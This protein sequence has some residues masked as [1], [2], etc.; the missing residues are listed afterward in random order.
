MS[1]SGQ[2]N[3]KGIFA[4]NWAALS[5]FLQFL[6][7]KNFA[8]IQLEPN[9]SEDFN[10][11]F[12]D[13]KKII[14][15]SKYKLGQF[16]YSQLKEVLEKIVERGSVEGRDEI[17]IVCRSVGQELISSTKNIRFS[18]FNKN[19][20]VK[21]K[22]K[23]FSEELFDL[24]PRVNFWPLGQIEDSDI[25]YSL[26]ADL[27]NLWVPA[28]EIQRFTNDILQ[29]NIFKKA[30][31]GSVYSREDFNKDLNDFRKEV[32]DR[33]DFFNLKKS[34]EEQ[35]T[36]LEGDVKESKGIEWGTGSV[37]AFSARWDLMSFA[38]DRL[39][40]RTDLNL[41]KWDD[42]W[43]LNRVYYFAFGI[44]SVFENNIVNDE[45]RRY[46]V[47][48]V[49]KYIKNIRG[50]YRS[51]FFDIHIVT[52]LTIIIDN[53]G[54]EKYLTDV[55]SIISDLII[56]NEKEFF[57]L[58]DNGYDS[59][60]WQKEEICKLLHKIYT[61]S[62][63]VLKKKILK[64]LSVGFNITEDDGEFN[65]HAPM[66]V[67]NIFREWLDEDFKNR[68]PILI[69]LISEQYERFY[70]KFGYRVGFDGWEHSG[71]G[72]SYHGNYQGSSYRISERYFVSFI[73][74]P[75]IR[76]FYDGDREFGWK[77][78]KEKLVSRE[79]QVSTKRPDFLNR[80]VYEIVLSRYLSDNDNESQEDFLI[81]KEFIL[82]RKGIPHKTDLIYQAISGEGVEGDK[83]W[84]LVKIT[85]EKYGIPVNPLAEKIIADLAKKGFGSAKDI[86]RQWFSDPKYYKQT[87]FS[88]DSVGT[89]RSFVEDNLDL[90]LELF[91]ILISN[92]YL[93]RE[94]SHKFSA[95]TLAVLLRDILNKDYAKGL[96][97]IRFLE[98]EDVLSDDQQIVY[99]FSLFNHHG[100]DD[101]DD[102]T[103][104]FR[105]YEEVVDPF[106]KNH[107]NDINKIGQRLTLPTA[108]E[109]FLQFAS[110]LAAKKKIKEAL[111]IVEVFITDPDPYLPGQDP[112]DPKN[113]YNEHKKIENGDECSTIASV[114]GYCGW[115]LMKCSVLNGR[116]YVPKVID[117]T[118]KLISDPNYY[119]V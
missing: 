46:I 47:E 91:T 7:D 76:K 29:K 49:K 30:T 71:G 40:T 106:L 107:R 17:L 84:Q 117:L 52:I 45:N 75:A 100:N 65:H 96:S 43:Q 93:K 53:N 102:P 55:F 108:R 61:R 112:R 116:D 119:V 85:V 5:L 68:M 87:L 18:A 115:V 103:L 10:L 64:L 14:C 3:Q 105:T 50:F 72:I 80:A 109:A 26:V 22:K 34:K 60:K 24:M 104:L 25:N 15:E 44:F 1:K 41:K 113:E 9:D 86:L 16:T 69:K 94:K 51:D 23:G 31:A 62:N 66:E 90:A 73:L 37:S 6:K 82:S 27:L 4:Q 83:K 11:V 67:Y 77:F 33:S 57:Y 13:G 98:S 36:K 63:N 54:G 21:L 92:E 95:F 97:V 19:L 99:S 20:K 48:Y 118:K 89:I 42:L 8:Y 59:D 81:L 78:I 58:K 32:Q 38:M 110:R 28:E 12:G 39:K 101:S 79:K 56:F 74:S 70:K 35:F 114:R 111:R 2:N 88:L